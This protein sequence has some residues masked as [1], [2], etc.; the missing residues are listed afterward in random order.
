LA[1]ILAGLPKVVKRK[2]IFYLVD[3]AM[4]LGHNTHMENE[5]IDRLED[6]REEMHLVSQNSCWLEIMLDRQNKLWDKL[7]EQEKELERQIN[8][9]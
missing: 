4:R 5:L 8:A 3:R 9:N 6:I 2:I 1:P 7:V